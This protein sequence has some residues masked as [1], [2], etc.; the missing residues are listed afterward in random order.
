MISNAANTP[1][2]FGGGDTES[3]RDQAL[4]CFGIAHDLLAECKA[5]SSISNLDTA[6]YLFRCTA[7]MWLPAD[8]RLGGCLGLLAT[9][10]LTRFGYTGAAQDVWDATVLRAAPETVDAEFLFRDTVSSDIYS[11]VRF[12]HLAIHSGPRYL[13]GAQSTRFDGPC[14]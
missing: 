3:D 13:G 4:K 11:S 2:N 5:A 14:C 1:D 8:I 12:I 10:L 7:Q 6:I 9:A